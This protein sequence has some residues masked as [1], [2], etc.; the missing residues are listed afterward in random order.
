MKFI[1]NPYDS[2]LRKT[3]HGKNLYNAWQR[4]RRLPHCNEW[5]TFPAFYEWA[6]QSGY[7]LGAW[8]RIIDR[9]DP[10]SPDNCWWHTPGDTDEEISY[11]WADSWN[12]TVNRIRKHYGMPPLEGTTYGDL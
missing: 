11:E 8:L 3:E 5:D 4:I 9:T 10:Y 12:K 2:S 7:T 1:G 6:M